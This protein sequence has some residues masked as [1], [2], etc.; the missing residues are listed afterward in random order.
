MWWNRII[1]CPCSIYWCNSLVCYFNY[2]WCYGGSSSSITSACFHPSVSHLQGTSWRYTSSTNHG[3]INMTPS[4]LG[5]TNVITPRRHSSANT[6][7][8]SKADLLLGH[9]LR[10]WPNI[11]PTSVCWSRMLCQILHILTHMGTR[12]CCDVETTSKWRWF[13]E[14]TSK[15]RWFNVATTSCAHGLHQ[16]HT[17]IVRNVLKNNFLLNL[18]SALFL[19]WPIFYQNVTYSVSSCSKNASVPKYK[20]VFFCWWIIDSNA[21]FNLWYLLEVWFPQSLI[22]WLVIPPQCTS[23]SNTRSV[24][25]PECVS[26]LSATCNVAICITEAYGRLQLDP[27][28]QYVFGKVHSRGRFII[29]DMIYYGAC[30][31]P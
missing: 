28:V 11:K 30:L 7:R 10:C 14:T 21:T 13:L 31:G 26:P 3:Q 23:V 4:E 1:F 16:I 5:R 19:L 29:G 6:E 20:F 17:I 18:H 22:I 27:I 9:R 2:L 12:R 25:L 15:W 8:L 24:S